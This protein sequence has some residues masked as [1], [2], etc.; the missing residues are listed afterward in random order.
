MNIFAKKV[1]KTRETLLKYRLYAKERNKRARNG[2][3]K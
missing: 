3:G 1:R 2:G